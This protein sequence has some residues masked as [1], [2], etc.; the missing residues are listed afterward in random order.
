M[1]SS[2]NIIKSVEIKK[3]EMGGTCSMSWSP[4]KLNTI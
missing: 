3:D 1:S 2:H 4:K